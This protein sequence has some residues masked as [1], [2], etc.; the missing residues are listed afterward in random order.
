M[1]RIHELHRL[2][3]LC[4]KLGRTIS[5]VPTQGL[6]SSDGKWFYPIANAIPCLLPED[7]W[8]LKPEDQPKKS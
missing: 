7:A 2:G 3:V 5:Y 8:D 6:V 4:T 1:N